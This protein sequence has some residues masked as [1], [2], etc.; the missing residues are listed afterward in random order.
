MWRHVL[1]LCCVWYKKF[2]KF[3]I[4]WIAIGNMFTSLFSS[5]W[6]LCLTKEQA[7]KSHFTGAQIV[8]IN[9][10]DGKLSVSSTK[11]NKFYPS[12]SREFSCAVSSF[13]QLFL[14]THVGTR[15]LF[16]ATSPLVASAFDRR[17]V[18]PTTNHLSRLTQGKNLWYPE[19]IHRP[20]LLHFYS[21]FTTTTTI[22]FLLFPRT[23]TFFCNYKPVA[24]VIA[25]QHWRRGDDVTLSWWDTYDVT[26][27]NVFVCKFMRFLS[28]IVSPLTTVIENEY[29]YR[30]QWLT[31]IPPATKSH[32]L[33]YQLF[34]FLGLSLQCFWNGNL[35]EWGL[36]KDWRQII[37]SF[38]HIPLCWK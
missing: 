28:L 2:D 36:I 6:G 4:A 26:D 9:R 24:P 15:G 33:Y 27:V 17:C 37:I 35:L 3:L 23:N 14:V 32:V 16:L 8:N 1:F 38:M 31:R 19:Y 5:F 7:Q 30:F 20:S 22:T 29:G 11:R 10:G 12:S 34:S 18:D 25:V 21:T 13:R